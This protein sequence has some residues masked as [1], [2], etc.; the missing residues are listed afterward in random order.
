M[1]KFSF[2]HHLAVLDAL[3]DYCNRRDEDYIRIDGSTSAEDRLLFA[4][5]F[6]NS[7]STRVAVLAITAAGISLPLLPQQRYI[8]QKC[9]GPPKSST[10]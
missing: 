4:H 9:I 10:G 7:S 3:C 8:L 1:V 2:A 6:Q 5:R